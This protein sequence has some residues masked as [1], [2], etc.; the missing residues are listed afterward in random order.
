MSDTIS[1][2]SDSNETKPHKITKEEREQNRRDAF[3]SFSLFAFDEAP[4]PVEAHAVAIE[5]LHQHTSNNAIASDTVDNLAQQKNEQHSSSDEK[6]INNTDSKQSNDKQADSSHKVN[7][8][9]AAKKSKKSS[10]KR[11]SSKQ[12]IQIEWH[13]HE[14]LYAD[15]IDTLLIDR[16]TGK[17][18]TWAVDAY[19]KSHGEGFG[20]ADEMKVAQ[21]TGENDDMVKPRIA[22]S[23]AAKAGRTKDKAEVFTPSWVCNLQ[24]N[25]V[26]KNWFGRPDTFN[27][28]SDDDRVWTPTTQHID[29]NGLQG[30]KTWETYVDENRM[31]ITCGEAPYLVSRYDTVSGVDIPLN[32]RIGLLDRKLRVIGE[33]CDKNDETQLYSLVKR[34]YKSIYGFEWQGD[35]LLL[36][37]KNLFA[38]FLDYWNAWTGHNPTIE[39][40]REIAEI[41]SWNIFQMDGIKMTLPGSETKAKIMDWGE[42]HPIVFESL[43]KH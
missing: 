11:K 34:A 9:T 20:F 40:K 35:N 10:S 3:G 17:N 36:A 24:N 32:S 19:E 43:A 39:Q 13:P 42:G 28:M 15:V 41:I 22:K 29:F 27:K 14:E 23:A 4:E 7:R 6:T 26:D 16:T 25:M 33:N 5:E 12:P 30:G 31:E 37:R 18:I 2:Q 1:K 38:T 8:K 21:V